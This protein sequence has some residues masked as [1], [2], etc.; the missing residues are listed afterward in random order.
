MDIGLL[1]LCNCFVCT[2]EWHISEVYEVDPGILCFVF[3]KAFLRYNWQI[4]CKILKVYNIMIWYT[5][6]LWK[7]SPHEVN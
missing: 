5:Y 7:E 2:I 4:N 3:G 1:F 6:I